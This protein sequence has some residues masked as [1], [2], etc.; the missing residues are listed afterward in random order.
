LEGSIWRPTRTESHYI[1]TFKTVSDEGI[2]LRVTATLQLSYTTK[3]HF[4]AVTRPI[5]DP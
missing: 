4:N 1:D 3:L 2:R 5:H